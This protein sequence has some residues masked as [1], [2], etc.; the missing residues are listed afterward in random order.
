MRK[1]SKFLPGLLLLIGFMV[2]ITMYSQSKDSTSW[3]TGADI[4]SSFI[5]RGTKY[6]NG[7]AIQPVLECTKGPFKIGAWG[8]F[9]FRGYQETDL[10]FSFTLFEGFSLGMTDYYSPDFRYFDYSRTSGRHAFEINI[11]YSRWNFNFSANYILN[12]AGDIGSLG[13]DLY[14]Q[15][16]Y[17]FNY[18]NLFAGAGNGWHTYE[19]DEEKNI[20]TVCN[21]G[22]ETS[23][24][25]PITDR[26]SL[27]V[28]GK[29]IF[30]PDKE[31]MFIVFGFKLQ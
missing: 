14:F 23:K 4:F 10:Y 17:S 19:P 27:P 30:N 21:I 1:Y 15:A 26:F 7:P 5:W 12:E 13:S 18:F 24:T 29:L 28:I 22:I 25:I 2:N 9:D 20:F 31:R 8:S 16:G 3:T 6:G 11:D